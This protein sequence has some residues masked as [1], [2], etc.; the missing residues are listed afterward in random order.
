[1]HKK[2]IITKWNDDKG[3]GFITP[4]GEKKEIFVHISEFKD[5]TKRPSLNKP[6]VYTLS[7]TKG[8]PCAINVQIDNNSSFIRKKGILTKWNEEKGYG[9][10]T[11]LGEKKEI[12]V[13]ISEFKGHP[14]LNERISFTLSKDKSGRT[15]ATNVIAFNQAR[16]KF[17][18]QKTSR[19]KLFSLSI[20][21]IFYGTL[22]YFTLN[23]KIE[24]Y[25][26]PYYLFI[27]TFTFYI[28]AKDKD[29]A[30]DGS[31]RVSEKTLHLLSL[32]GGWTGALIAQD[33]LQHKSSKLSFK[34]TFF[35]TILFN[36][37]LLYILNSLSSNFR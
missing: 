37:L 26:L 27:S 19:I 35:I 18:S 21:I 34:L 8:K 13:H 15:C 9:F 36:L 16:L 4:L 31:W 29:Y 10:I 30:Q 7:Q 23:Q 5:R 22:L 11:P 20:I 3:F 14:L 17:E 2:G 32:I 12:F 24:A 6:V 28:Y 33:K 25:I 1:M